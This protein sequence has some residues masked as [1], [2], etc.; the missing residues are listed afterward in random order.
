MYIYIHLCP[1]AFTLLF[2]ATDPGGPAVPTDPNKQYE[3]RCPVHGFIRLNSWE[4]E[5]VNHPVFQRLRRIRQLGWT[6]YIYPGAMH[7][8]F[9]HSLG[10]MHV[11]TR[12]FDA[13]K[14][15]SG[16]VLEEELSYQ[17]SAWERHRQIV[18]LAALLHDVGH[19]PFSHAGEDLMPGRVDGKGRHNH[20]DY[21]A[22]II[23]TALKNIIND[24]Q[25]NLANWGI[26]AENIAALLEGKTEAAETIFWRDLV[27]GQLD[28]DRMDYLLRDALHT[29][30]SSG[31][32]DLARLVGTIVAIPPREDRGPRL[33]I[34][35]GGVHAAESLVLARY[36]M[37][38]Q[39]YF[40]R[41]R[42]AYDHHLHHALKEILPG[43]TFPIPINPDGSV[44]E[45]S[46]KDYLQWDDWRVLGILQQ[47]GGGDHGQRL[48][49]RNHYRE[50]FHTVESPSKEQIEECDEVKKALG[51][52]AVHEAIA[53]KAWYKLEGS[54]V[55]VHSS[56][57]SES[58]VKPLSHHSTLVRNLQPIAQRRLYVDEA[59]KAEAD[60]LR[61]GV[62]KK[63]GERP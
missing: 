60:S 13:I 63:R 61:D 18:R 7:T 28:A 53:G 59:K 34:N 51:D 39:V 10:V 45:P 35:E 33:G 23:R 2:S 36:F 54:D 9:E 8:R 1:I 16:K 31:G 56:S 17:S 47:G 14:E 11:A 57:R 42:I 15:R 22:A 62:L 49:E 21:S 48:S 58:D 46:I 12:L 27:T 6:D 25:L 44:N 5:I 55:P 40:H 38:T 32:F 50:V 52:L 20:E 41:V 30:A 24:H 3:F 19:G 29:V 37:F 26:Q 4:K 43:G